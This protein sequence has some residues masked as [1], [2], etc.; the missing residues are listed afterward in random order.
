MANRSLWQTKAQAALW[1]TGDKWEKRKTVLHE[2]GH[3]LGVFQ[4]PQV[5]ELSLKRA[6]GKSEEENGLSG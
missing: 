5:R 3:I 2:L 4:N 1:S 6:S